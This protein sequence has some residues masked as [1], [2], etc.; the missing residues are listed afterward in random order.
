MSQR[1]TAWIVGIVAVFGFIASL[2]SS[3]HLS[4]VINVGI[5]TIAAVG[6]SLVFGQIGA[7]NMGQAAFFGLGGYTAGVVAVQFKQSAL[8]GIL[9][10]IS[11]PILLALPIGWIVL[12]LSG[13][14]LAMA[15]LA[16][17]SIVLASLSQFEI[18]PPGVSGIPGIPSIIIG[19][20]TFENPQHYAM[21]VWAIALAV[22]A[23]S[24]NLLR[25]RVGRALRAIRGS[26]TAAMVTGIPVTKYKLMMFVFGCALAGLG[27]SLSAHFN[28]FVG[29]DSAALGLSIFLLVAVV[30][31]GKGSIWGAPLGV[32]A[33]VLLIEAVS[34]YGRYEILAYGIVLTLAL[35]YFPKGLA[36]LVESV[37]ARVTRK[38][39]GHS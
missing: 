34:K 32:A 23:F 35:M 22:L 6:M 11:V 14:Y 21:L 19:D 31:G 7:L 2:D 10:A 5:N 4:L 33:L 29:P 15:T 28:S 17:N 39:G 27:G 8:L 25:S 26:E 3:Y 30:V 13:F 18:G 1:W 9:G 37:H 16:L 20:I 38:P 36:G 24:D 12:R